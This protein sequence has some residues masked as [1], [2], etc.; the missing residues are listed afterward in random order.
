MNTSNDFVILQLLAK[1]IRT[2]RP[3]PAEGLDPVREIPVSFAKSIEIAA[4]ILL[5][6]RTEEINLP[7]PPEIKIRL[8]L[9]KVETS[10][11]RIAKSTATATARLD[12]ELEAIETTLCRLVEAVEF[13]GSNLSELIDRDAEAKHA[14]LGPRL[15]RAWWAFW[16]ALDE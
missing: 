15:R 9:D 13:T 5:S 8:D 11:S 10:L 16:R 2:L 14:R 4:T 6:K 7:A 12:D 1:K 3:D